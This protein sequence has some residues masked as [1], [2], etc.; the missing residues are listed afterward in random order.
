MSP[1]EAK[2]LAREIVENGTVAFSG[3]AREE[4]AKDGLE[5]TDC[6]N[7]IRAGVYEPAEHIN[8]EWRY[9][10]RTARICVVIA[11]PSTTRLRVIT[12]WRFT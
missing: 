8:G 9:R 7:L 4:M 10:C 12:A 1:A 3:H 11:F 5:T 2:R 6:L